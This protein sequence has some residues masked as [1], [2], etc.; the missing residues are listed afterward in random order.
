[1]GD[2]AAGDRERLS[3]DPGAEQDR[4]DAVADYEPFQSCLPVSFPSISGS[5][6]STGI[7]GLR[8]PGGGGIG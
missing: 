8:L 7:V 3:L 2:H 5:A 4:H 1:M 6:R